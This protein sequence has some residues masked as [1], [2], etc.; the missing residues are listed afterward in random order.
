MKTSKGPVIIY[1]HEGG[2]G[3]I[4]WG[5]PLIFGGKNGGSPETLEGFREG[6]TQIFL[7]NEDM[8]GEGEWGGEG[9]AKVIKCYSVK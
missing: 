4:L 6:T 3:A 5:D 9:I 8:V 1:R 2:G 7:E